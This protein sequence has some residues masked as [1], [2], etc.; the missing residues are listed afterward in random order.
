M[1][2]LY[3]IPRVRTVANVL[4]VQLLPQ[5]TEEGEVSSTGRRR[6]MLKEML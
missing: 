6:S 3:C 4:H 5:Q 1:Y 2:I